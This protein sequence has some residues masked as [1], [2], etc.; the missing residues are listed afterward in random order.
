MLV[1]LRDIKKLEH[2]N[3]ESKYPY[4]EAYKAFKS[5]YTLKQGLKKTLLT[6]L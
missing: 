4:M 2:K 1:L 6:H 5:L 3:D